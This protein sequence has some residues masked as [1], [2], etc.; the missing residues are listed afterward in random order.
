MGN[1]RHFDHDIAQAQTGEINHRLHLARIADKDRAPT[2]HHGQQDQR[3]GRDTGKAQRHPDQQIAPFILQDLDPVEHIGQIGGLDIG[4][5][6]GMRIGQ[7]ACVEHVIAGN[8][9][10]CAFHM[11]L[12]RQ[13]R[14]TGRRQAD[15]ARGFGRGLACRIQP[16]GRRSTGTENL[17]AVIVEQFGLIGILIL[18]ARR[19]DFIKRQQPVMLAQ[20]SRVRFRE[21]VALVQ[22]RCGREIARHHKEMF[23][24]IG[25]ADLARRRHH[26]GI[27][28]QHRFGRLFFVPDGDREQTVGLQ[29]PHVMT[30]R[31]A[32]I[33]KFFDNRETAGARQARRIRQRQIDH[34]EPV[35]HPRQIKA[36]V[37]INH[38]HIG[39]V[40]NIAG[41]IAQHL[42]VAKHIQHAPVALGHRDSGGTR[43]QRQRGRQAAAELH[44]KG[45]G[46][47]LEQIG[48][49]HRQILVIGGFIGRQLPDDTA[50]PLAVLIET[51]IGVF[52]HFRQV[53]SGIV[54][55][56]GRKMQIGAGIDLQKP[57][58]RLV[59]QHA[60]AIGEFAGI[61][62]ALIV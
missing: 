62:D 17:V 15:I 38:L 10:P 53:E 37:I 48:I 2:E 28:L 41:E 32:G 42:V 50:R 51:E 60:L 27:E 18:E 12:P 34:I 52:R 19:I 47:G 40:E 43:R 1:Q 6:I 31:L 11:R 8:R 25:A 3:K 7:E 56:A 54:R 21:P 45:I 9:R 16:V 55:Q 59:H 44:H 23:G 46:L 22:N 33:G 29:G 58:R 35:S 20:Q 30:H 36:A 26:R 13:T 14:Q 4:G 57:E 49:N 39:T 24:D 61:A 5:K